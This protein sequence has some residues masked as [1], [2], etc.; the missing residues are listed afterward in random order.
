M[1]SLAPLI[2]IHDGAQLHPILVEFLILEA[3]LVEKDTQ[4]ERCTL[5]AGREMDEWALRAAARAV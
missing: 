3:W 4:Q 2:L 1:A 5:G